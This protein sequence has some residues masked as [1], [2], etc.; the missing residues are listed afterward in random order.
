[1]KRF[2][3]LFPLVI[4]PVIVFLLANSTGSP[5]GKTGSPGDA[6][7]TCTQC[8]TGTAQTATNWITTNIPA[9]G[10]VPGQS[11]IITATGFHMGVVKIGFELTAEN[12]ANDKV[13]TFSVI[14]A[15]ETQLVNNNN[16]VTHKVGGTTPIGN[17]KI[18]TMNWVAPAATTGAVTFYA[19]F[20]AANGNGNNQ[21]D[22]IY[23]S[24]LTVQPAAAGVDVTFQVD[25]SEQTVSPLG[26]HVAGSFQGWAPGATEMLLVSDAIYA[27][28]VNLNPGDAIEYKFVNGNAWGMDEQV[29]AGCAQNNNRFLTVPSTNTVLTAVCFGSCIVCNP[30]LV[31]ITFQVDMSNETVSTNGVHVAGSFQGWDPASTEMLPVGNDVYAVTLPIEA[32]NYYEYKFVNGNTWAGGE[33]VPAACAVGWNRFITVP[34][35]PTTL[36]AVCFGSCYPCGPPPIDI[37]IT[38][39]VDMSEQVISPDGMHIAGGFQGWDPGSTLMNDAGNNIYTFTT[40]LPSGTYQE[41]KFVNGIDWLS[42]ENVP[43]EC[44]YNNNRYLTVPMTN[45]VLPLVCYGAC[46]PCGPPPVEIDV[47]FLVDMTNEVVSADGVHLA[48]TF[49]GWNASSTP[50]TDMGDN[51]YAATVTLLSGEYHEY[52]FINGISFDFTEIVPQECGVDDGQGGFNRFLTVPLNDTTLLPL[53][54]GSCDICLPPQPFHN[55]VFRVDMSNETVSADGVHIAGEFQGWNP[56]TT[57]MSNIGNNIYAFQ[58][59][60]EEGTS[61][62]YKYINGNTFDFAENVPGMCAQNGNRFFTVPPYDTMLNL[63]CFSSCNPCVPPVDVDVTF[64]VDMTN[65]DVST[66]GI[67][68]AGSFQGWDPASTALTFLSNEIYEVTLTMT[69][70]EYHEYKFINGNTF[71]NAE[72][73]PEACG[74]PDGFG[75]FSRYFTVPQNDTSFTVV[76]FGTCEACIPPLPDHQVTFRVD[77]T[78]ETVAAEGVHLAGTFQGWN[79]ASTPMANVGSNIYEVSIMLEE[80]SQHEYKFINGNTFSNAEIV[81]PGCSQNNNRFLTVPA[82]NIILPSV[83]FS[84]CDPC[85]PPPVEVEVTFQVDMANVEIISPDGV[86]ITGSFQGWDPGATAM[87]PGIDDVFYYTAVL[88]S[89]SYHEYKFVNGNAWGQQETVPD[90]C[91]YN[92]NRFITV[93]DVN[94][95]LTD[96]CFADCDT[97][98]IDA[99]PESQIRHDRVFGF[100]PNPATKNIYFVEAGI[101]RQITIL[102]INGKEMLNSV[103]KNT[104]LDISA[105]PQGLYFIKIKYQDEIFI[106]KLII[107]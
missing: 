14:N 5:G 28:T 70:G 83:C 21:G 71:D 72:I 37:E 101:E 11:Y 107:Q 54:F 78:Y 103:I 44:G 29:P 80:A 39:Q 23:K 84:S 31:N 45:T 53:C 73:V 66:N 42:A 69:A 4:L 41:Y 88:Q 74:V 90:G 30:P 47:T 16:A 25:M 105:L 1:M 48:G 100:Y 32:G 87:L 96:V 62:E 49:Q 86:H 57:L 91:S 106:D 46:G 2:Y 50:M 15:N 36:D 33:T 98:I 27:V 77:M 26:V 13:G 18:W 22:V 55:V 97:C 67:H 82:T 7:V 51:V 40:I 34:S 68:V 17:S 75:G 9:S 8:H 94:T 58:T 76:C 10:Y 20:N 102:S 56:A 38:F 52:K 12:S 19:A 89:G 104:T 24:S 59:L 35:V 81:P 95:V 60:L 65:E 92:N 85:G 6:G 63:V 99:I 64:L 79:P 93:P 43:A 61:Q 3:R